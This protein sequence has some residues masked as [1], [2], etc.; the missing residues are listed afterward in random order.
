MKKEQRYTPHYVA[1]SRGMLFVFFTW[2]ELSRMIITNPVSEGRPRFQERIRHY[3]FEV[4]KQLCTYVIDPQ[5]DPTEALLLYLILL[6]GLSL[7]ELCHAQLPTLHALRPD[8]P[9][10]SLAEAYAILLPHR[11]GS[12]GR[13]APG[14][15]IVKLDFPEKAQEFL[16][17]L[18]VRFEQQRAELIK[19]PKNRYVFISAGVAGTHR[20]PAP[21][22][23]DFLFRKIRA[24]TRRLV[25][26]P[27]NPRTL[28]Q[29]TG[30]LY[31]DRAGGS[32]L[33]MMGW[34]GQQAY[35]Y[36]S[37]PRE[38]VDPRN[39]EPANA[40]ILFPSPRKELKGR[41]DGESC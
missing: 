2:T 7:Q 19:N 40:E 17:P 1:L 8:I 24:I 23:G 26:F 32:I 20:H 3:P 16:K 15:P 34:K 31:A 25:G 18:L 12:R 41:E 39:G 14:R 33:Q 21:V 35:L 4:V 13:R 29:T 27:C 11:S 38:L 5:A 9:I 30:L 36:L 22:S 6:E 10:P 28:R 37:A